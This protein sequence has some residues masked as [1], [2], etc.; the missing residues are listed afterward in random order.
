MWNYACSVYLAAQ[1]ALEWARTREAAITAALVESELGDSE[2]DMSV[3]KQL[4]V[5][6]A[7]LADGEALSLVMN[8]AARNGWEAWRKLNRRLDPQ[9]IGQQTNAMANILN[10]KPCSLKELPG[11]IEKWEQKV[12][13]YT[14]SRGR[15][16]IEGDTLTAI[17]TQMCLQE[18]QQRIRLNYARLRS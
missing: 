5:V 11:A 18:L 14:D 16:P 9:I 12:R 7:D 3:G 13:H 4:Y 15:G 17:L 1:E 10:V 8:T 2:L 6:L